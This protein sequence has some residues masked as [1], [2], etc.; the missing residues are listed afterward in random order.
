M[1]KVITGK[2]RASY[3]HLSKPQAG[4]GGG[5]E[6]YSMSG[7]IDKSDTAT[8]ENIEKAIE[9]ATKEGIGRLVLNLVKLLILECLL[10]M[11]I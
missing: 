9:K 10:E 8:I 11:E 4:I 1:T 2:T 5:E 6:K 7:I 3:A